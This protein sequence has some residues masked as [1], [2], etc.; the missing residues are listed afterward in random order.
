MQTF[1]F[2]KTTA[3]LGQVPTFAS[4]CL[5]EST[6]GEIRAADRLGLA[7]MRVSA[8]LHSPTI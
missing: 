1:D 3:A 7:E 4:G 6:I 2:A 5:L 8:L